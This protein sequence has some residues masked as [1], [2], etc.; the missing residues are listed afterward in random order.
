MAA[1]RYRAASF[2]GDTDAATGALVRLLL[3]W[4]L[5]AWAAPSWGADLHDPDP[6]AIPA[7]MS[8]ENVVKAIKNAMVVQ[9][10]AL[11]NEAPGHIVA[12]FSPNDH[13][14]R[15]TISYDEKEVRVA[16]LD[17]VNPNFKEEDGQR[18]IHRNYNKWVEALA[19]QIGRF[20]TGGDPA[21]AVRGVSGGHSYAVNPPPAEKFSGFNHFELEHITM[22][23][24]YAGQGPN[25]AAAAKIEEHMQNGLAPLFSGWGA[26]APATAGKRT[27]LVQPHVQEI[28]FIGGGARFF[29]GAMAGSSYVTLRVRYVDA[30]SG[31]TV[32]EPQFSIRSPGRAGFMGIA[33]NE[34]LRD[35]AAM[36]RDYTAN[37]YDAAIGGPVGETMH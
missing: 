5:L 14:A 11:D 1:A 25:E 31:K 32:A 17:S 9:A 15:V 23:A 30:A 8:G 29:V 16:Y 33:D 19:Q 22:D 37:N 27:L 34:M 21:F 7:G 36:V 3:V 26:A 6:V 13:V 28:K 35:I 18:E 12:S 24:P 20:D 2:R 4:L 10:W